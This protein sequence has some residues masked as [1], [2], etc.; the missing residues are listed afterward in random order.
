MMFGDPDKDSAYSLNLTLST[1]EDHLTV[2][3][4]E[5]RKSTCKI[6]ETWKKTPKSKNVKTVD[7]GWYH[8]LEEGND[9]G[10]TWYQGT[11]YND[12]VSV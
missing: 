5:C 8:M 11:L 10:S 1:T 12:P 2:V 3:S 7:S 9:I 6:N 4:K